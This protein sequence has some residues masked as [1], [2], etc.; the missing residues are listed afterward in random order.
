LATHA[1]KGSRN[2][3]ALAALQQDYDDQ[4]EAHYSVKDGNE[5]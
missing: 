5:N 3:T 1:S 4:K 2:I